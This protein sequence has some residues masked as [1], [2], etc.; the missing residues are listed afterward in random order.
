MKI[1]SA[2]QIRQWDAYT[3]GHE[4]VSSIDL[5]ERAATACYEWISQ[6]FPGT[7]RYSIFCGTGNNGGDGLAIARMLLRA[8]NTVSIFILEGEK[9][10]GDFSE[11]LDRLETLNPDIQFINNTDFHVIPTG[12]IVIEALFGSGLS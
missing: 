2:A 6:Q 8:H 12:T 7:N 10:S 3:I 9:R 1:F 4:P 5:M 11:N